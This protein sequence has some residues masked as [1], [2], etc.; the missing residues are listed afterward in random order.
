MYS[1]E[2][3]HR[4]EMVFDISSEDHTFVIDAK[5]GEGAT[6]PGVLLASLGSCVGVYLR[7]YSE[8]SG[9]RLENFRITV[10]AEFTPSPLSFKTIQVAVDLKGA[11]LDERRQKALLEFVKNCPVHNTLKGDPAVEIKIGP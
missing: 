8:G 5:A 7:K 10:K 3:T 9:L 4:Q 2:V 1:V 11:D 6:P